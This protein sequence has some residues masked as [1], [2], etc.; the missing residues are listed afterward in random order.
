MSSVY[1]ENH[2]MYQ[3][4]REGGELGADVGCWRPKNRLVGNWIQVS[5]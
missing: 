5:L 3:L 4:D 2:T 1:N